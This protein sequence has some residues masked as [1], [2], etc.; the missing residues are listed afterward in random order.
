MRMTTFAFAALSAAALTFG[1][2]CRGDDDGDGDSDNPGDSDSDSDVTPDGPPAGGLV[3]IKDI[4]NDAMPDGTA[5]EVEGVIVTAVDRFGARQSDFWVQDPAGGELSG[6]H[7]FGAPLDAVA[8]LEVG[9][10]V[11][12]EGGKKQEFRR[13][14]FQ[15]GYSITELVPETT[16]SMVVTVT[17]ST[18][19]PAPAL[20]DALAIAQLPDF[21][22][23]HAEWEKWEG[24]LIKVDN[25]S[26]LGAPRCVGSACPDDTNQTLDITGDID[27]QSSIAAFP[28]SIA[29]GAC[30]ASVTGVVDYFYD[31]HIYNRTTED[32]AT[33]GTGC[34]AENTLATCSDELDNDGNGFAD[35]EDRNCFGVNPS[36][37]AAA[38]VVAVQTGVATGVVNLSNVFVTAVDDVGAKGLWVADAL[39]AAENNGVYVYLGNV[40]LPA[41]IAIGATVDVTGSVVEFDNNGSTGDKLTEITN[42]T[43]A[44]TGAPGANLPTPATTATVTVLAN[45]GAAGEPWEGVLVQVPTMKVTSIT[46]GQGKVELT[47]NTGAKLIMDNEAFDFNPLPAV[48]TC[49]ASL[50][51]VMHVQT[52]D[53]LRTINPRHMAD[54]VVGAGCTP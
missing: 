45:I 16:G 5:V 47:D 26:T 35:C 41:G 19:P 54:M 49:Y 50:T 23:R 20:V 37:S 51:G 48:G 29:A 42:A 33:G 22:A 10:I 8:G 11:K 4:Q 6:I 30:L 52:Q 27:I 38:T 25:V 7:V 14:D 46:V 34:A 2:A 53:D 43:A 12:I 17:S 44:L 28:A 13:D 24:V 36:C 39:A 9:D 40:T 18:T 3:N 1:G 32:V 15:E 31:Y 21:M